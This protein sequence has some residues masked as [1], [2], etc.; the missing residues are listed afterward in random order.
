VAC[1]WGWGWGTGCADDGWCINV[2]TM[3]V[4]RMVLSQPTI[5]AAGWSALVE[6]TASCSCS[7]ILLIIPVIAWPL[8][9]VVCTLFSC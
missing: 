3:Q 5:A 2:K 7:A 4:R 1:V 8:A 9:Q 6:C